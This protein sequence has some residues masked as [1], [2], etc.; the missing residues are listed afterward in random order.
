MRIAFFFMMSIILF[1][2]ATDADI[3]DSE[4]A[5]GNIFTATTLDITQNQTSNNLPVSSL[6]NVTSLIPGGFEIRTVRI[7]K[8]GKMDFNY[9]ITASQTVGDDNFCQS[10]VIVLL[11]DWQIKYEGEIFELS[12]DDRINEN[13]IDDWVVLVKL[14][15]N[16]QALT[17][18]ECQFDIIFN[19][20]K[21]DPYETNGFHD[22]EVIT[23][24]I[25]SGNWVSNEE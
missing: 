17:E 7:K 15:N 12:L 14:D 22:E 3:S 11:Q 8:A 24:R 25:T 9:R 5:T 2:G 13:G 18:K 16:N 4:V 1:S 10:L 6:F 23:N 21:N 19:T 20:W